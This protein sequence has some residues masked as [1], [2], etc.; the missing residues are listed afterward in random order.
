MFNFPKHTHCKNK[1]FIVVGG[2]NSAMGEALELSKFANKITVVYET[3]VYASPTIRDQVTKTGKVTI[4]ENT[5]VTDICGQESVSGIMLKNLKT[6]ILKSLSAQGI[7][8]SNGRPVNTLLFKDKL[9]MDDE[10]LIKIHSGRTGCSIPGVVVGDAKRPLKYRKLL[11]AAGDG[12]EAAIDV[13]E[14]LGKI[15]AKTV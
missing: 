7:F 6:G 2:G 9:D 15:A 12:T 10:G 11:A 8:V 4:L 3:T 14:Y 13:K 1:H 5:L